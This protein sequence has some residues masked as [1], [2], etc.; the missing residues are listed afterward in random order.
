MNQGTETKIPN[1]LSPIQISVGGI[2][3]SVQNL[4][5]IIL[6]IDKK[7]KPIQ[8]ETSS[9]GEVAQSTPDVKKSSPMNAE[10][11]LLNERIINSIVDLEHIIDVIEL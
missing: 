5:S 10:L 8:L 11:S 7:T 4:E 1:E 9:R 3:D 6:K 2:Q